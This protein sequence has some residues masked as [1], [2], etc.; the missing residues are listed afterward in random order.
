MGDYTD[1]Q[2]FYLINGEELVNVDQDI[3]YNFDRADQRIK[4]LVEYQV[5][6]VPNLSVATVAK[7]TG[8]KWYK[9]F[10]NSVWNYRNG[11]LGQDVNSRI[12][13][14]SISGI[15]F[16]SGYG[17]ANLEEG[18]IAW[19]INDGFA[20]LRGRL[21]LNGGTIDLPRNTTTKFMTLPDV[22]L[23]VKARY[24]TVYGGNAGT[25]FQMARIYIPARTSSDKNLEFCKYGGVST[26]NTEKYISLNDCR[27]ALED[28]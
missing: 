10:T 18:R 3:N 11:V 4:P 5:T 9:T 8:F 26:V 23:P 27:Y 6:D 2:K 1:T 7:E 19:S 16:Q 14:W 25:D 24:V 20:T 21:V 12:S 15:L 17:S 22:A 28:T 13:E